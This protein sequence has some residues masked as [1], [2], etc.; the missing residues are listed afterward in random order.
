MEL[1]KPFLL[2]LLQTNSQRNLNGTI[3]SSSIP[4]EIASN[5][6]AAKFIADKVL[7]I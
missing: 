3:R 5:S 7:E 6:A 4:N 2:A 1:L